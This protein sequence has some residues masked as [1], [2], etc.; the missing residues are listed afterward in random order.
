[1]NPLSAQ[2][3]SSSAFSIVGDSHLEQRCSICCVSQA[4]PT[5]S[6]RKLFIYVFVCLYVCVLKMWALLYFKSCHCHTAFR[7]LINVHSCSWTWWKSRNLVWKQTPSHLIRWQ[8]MECVSKGQHFFFFTHN[9]WNL[10]MRPA[11]S[12]GTLGRRPW[13][14]RGSSDEW[15]SCSKSHQGTL[16]LPAYVLYCELMQ[17]EVS[18]SPESWDLDLNST[19]TVGTTPWM[20][21]W[22]TASFH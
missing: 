15:C 7:I 12:L 21:Q 1:M 9:L 17:T 8:Q 6:C 16:S 5:S 14:G 3:E 2:T 11:S 19:Q 10:R 20:S 18:L 22:A 4:L 13:K